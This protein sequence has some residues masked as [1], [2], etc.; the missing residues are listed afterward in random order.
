[1]EFVENTLLVC[2]QVHTLTLTDDWVHAVCRHT[3]LC[4]LVCIPTPSA[5]ISRP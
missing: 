2:T 4:H 1:M 3:R 5:F